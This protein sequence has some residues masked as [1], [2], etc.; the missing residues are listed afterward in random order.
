M[1]SYVEKGLQVERLK[2]NVLSLELETERRKA[3]L[4]AAEVVAK[5]CY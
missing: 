1:E 4:V 5:P 3:E 2:E